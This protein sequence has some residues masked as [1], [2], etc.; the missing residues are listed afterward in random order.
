MS[1][2]RAFA[3]ELRLRFFAASSSVWVARLVLVA[4]PQVAVWSTAWAGHAP[5]PW[6]ALALGALSL[7][8]A[9]LPES[10]VGTLALV[11][12]VAW[13][14][15]G[16]RDGMHPAIT[17]AGAG[18]VAA[19]VAA[20]LLAAGPETLRL[21]GRV[22]RRWCLRGV[23]VLGVVPLLWWVGE[24][25]TRLPQTGVVWAAALV[26]LLVVVLLVGQV[27]QESEETAAS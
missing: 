22:V 10:H 3:Y 5:R 6:W 23:A 8:H 20:I 24:N 27:T 17:L 11:L 26:V 7:A 9:M 15:W 16:L 12:P 1:G 18:L 13:W 2:L 25:V 4:G 14:G 21:D 19:H